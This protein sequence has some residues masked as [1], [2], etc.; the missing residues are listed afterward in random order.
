[1]PNE[2]T[3][4]VHSVLGLEAAGIALLGAT[5]LMVVGRLEPHDALRDIGV[6]HALLLLRR[7]FMLIEA[8]VHVGICGR[9]RRHAGR[10][11]YHLRVARRFA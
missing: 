5:V 8:V 7:L 10:R 4:S 2:R 1:M 9:D 6:E 11:R 3:W